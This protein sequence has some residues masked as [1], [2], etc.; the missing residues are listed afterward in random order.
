MT[1][2]VPLRVGQINGGGATNALFLKVWSGEVLTAFQTATQVV[3]RHT[4]RSISSGSSAQ[5]PATWRVTAGYHTP[6]TFLVGQT[7]NVAERVINIDDML[8]SSVFIPKI[9]EAMNHYDYRSIYSKETGLAL[10]YAWDRN[11]LQVS[12][13]AARAAA[14]VT[15]SNGG[16]VST[17][18]GTLYRTSA[19]DLANGIYLAM[20]NFDEKDIPESDP[21]FCF[22]RPAQYYLLA[23]S[24]NLINRDW[25]GAGSYSDGKILRIGGAEIIKTNNL[26]ISNITTGPVAYQGNFVPTAAVVMTAAAVGTV[27]LMDLAT[28]MEYE[29]QRQGTL[30]VSKYAV[31]HGIL[32]PECAVELRVT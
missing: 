22:V 23:Q 19:T 4:V 13:N 12:V 6:G 7:S 17:S 15:G 28:E 24:T 30:I 29:I 1:N 2:A 32:R 3:N 27:K 11:V 20:Q 14:T 18:T 25:M 5:F 10:A 9:D 26:P 16:F 8:L 31:G 21:K